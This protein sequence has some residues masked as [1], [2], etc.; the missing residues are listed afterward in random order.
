M[1]VSLRRTVGGRRF[2]R[3]YAA[4]SLKRAKGFRISHDWRE[5]FPRLYAA[6]SLKRRPCSWAPR[7]PVEISAA[8]CRGLIEAAATAASSD[9]ANGGFPRLYAAASLKHA[10]AERV[11]RCGARFPRL[12]AAASLKLVMLAWRYWPGRGFPRLYAAAS[13]KLRWMPGLEHRLGGGFPRL[14]AAASLKR[15]PP[16]G[17][18]LARRGISAALCRG[19]IEASRALSPPP[20]WDRDFRGFMP[21]PH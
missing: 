14:Y 12:Y 9:S 2:P 5:R 20:I 4:A 7:P 16:P 19:L 1:M 18:S 3:L 13:L 6:A 17:T 21:R 10:R 11:V 15:P 8:L